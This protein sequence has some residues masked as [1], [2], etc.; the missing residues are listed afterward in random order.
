[1]KDPFKQ[2]YFDII[3]RM[4]GEQA[5]PSEDD[6]QQERGEELQLQ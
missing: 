2:H 4:N 6:W 5:A 3:H 1:M